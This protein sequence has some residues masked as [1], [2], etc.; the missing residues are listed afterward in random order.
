[1]NGG[2]HSTG[3]VTE[4]LAKKISVG[5]SRGGGGG[6]DN[7]A[8][9]AAETREKH[10]NETPRWCSEFKRRQPKKILILTLDPGRGQQTR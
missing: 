2:G 3:R 6:G 4:L 10:K 8:F 1:M 5:E 7:L 9:L